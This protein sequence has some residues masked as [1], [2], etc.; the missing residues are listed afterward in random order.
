MVALQIYY[1]MFYQMGQDNENYLLK[2]GCLLAVISTVAMIKW[3]I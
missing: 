2:I 1:I 3:T